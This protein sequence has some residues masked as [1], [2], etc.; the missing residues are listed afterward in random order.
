MT[1]DD[2]NWMDKQLRRLDDD[3]FRVRVL[4]ARSIPVER[5][6]QLGLYLFDLEMK[7][8]FQE[9]VQEVDEVQA[10]QI[11]HERMC[12]ERELDEA[13]VYFNVDDFE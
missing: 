11:L 3:L 12:Q 10:T 7:Q 4:W 1:S 8:A 9:I 13:G 6:I 2:A 5:K